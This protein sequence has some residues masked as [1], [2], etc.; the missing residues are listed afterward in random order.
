MQMSHDV[1]QIVEVWEFV[2]SEKAEGLQ[3]RLS[4]V[5]NE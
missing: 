2:H 1:K 5:L 3:K 4:E